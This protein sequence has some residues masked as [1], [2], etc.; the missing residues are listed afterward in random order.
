MKFAAEFCWEMKMCERR[1]HKDE[2]AAGEE[3]EKKR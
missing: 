2:L 1:S 3:E